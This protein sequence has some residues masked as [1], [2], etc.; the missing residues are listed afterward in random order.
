[1][2]SAL[3]QPLSGG[4]ASGPRAMHILEVQLILVASRPEGPSLPR[5]RRISIPSR[6]PRP[7]ATQGDLHA[8]DGGAR[9]RL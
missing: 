1:M 8:R 4:R 7:S 6:K 5:Y 2:N 9:A 3:V